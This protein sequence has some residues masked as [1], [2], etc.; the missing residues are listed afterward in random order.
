MNKKRIVPESF[1]ALLLIGLFLLPVS[2]YWT[3][4]YSLIVQRIISVPDIILILG[5]L[6]YAVFSIKEKGIVNLISIPRLIWFPFAVLFSLI[7]HNLIFSKVSGIYSSASA[8]AL[9][10][11][12]L[13]FLLSFFA[14]GSAKKTSVIRLLYCYATIMVGGYFILLIHSELVVLKVI[15]W[16]FPY[17]GAISFPF[18]NPN[19]AAL[20]GTLIMLVGVGA[21]LATRKFHLLYLVVPVML[22]AV[23]Q[24]GS[25]SVTTL[26]ILV[27][28]GFVLAYVLNRAQNFYQRRQP[29]VHLAL[30][31]GLGLLLLVLVAEHAPYGVGRAI[32]LFPLLLTSPPDLVIGAVDS[33]RSE[34][35]AKAF[36]AV[37][38]GAPFNPAV[39]HNAYLEFA[40]YA[41]WS[42]LL[43]FIVFIVS[44]LALAT[45]SAVKNLTS[46]QWPLFMGVLLGLVVI[47]GAIYANPLM[48]LRYVWV[49][50]G[51][52][53]ATGILAQEN[54]EPKSV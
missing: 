19:Q 17:Y 29:L 26:A 9:S 32:S 16:E 11:G 31:Y 15:R 48:H 47:L 8:F 10:G 44:L 42:S 14:I 36:Q 33:Y 3:V 21:I 7:V 53:A 4:S 52:V 28:A 41:G 18:S 40:L 20:F 38:V 37:M 51:L 22:L 6:G 30:S 50:F 12:L 54:P 34:I 2:Q 45:T 35:W 39:V 1:A 43:L 49:F 25:R 5:G 23:A 46:A 13:I 24:T 27:M